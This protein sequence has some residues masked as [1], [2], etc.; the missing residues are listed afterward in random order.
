MKD[1]TRFAQAPSLPVR[2]VQ[3][4]G[5]VAVLSALALA[6]CGGGGAE[7]QQNPITSA[8]PASDYTG[9]APGTADV[10]AFMLNLWTNVKPGNRCGAC[11]NEGGQ[12]PSFG[13]NDDVNLAYQEA[14][15]IVD[16]T[17]PGNSRMVTKVAGGH[18]CW[19]T[20]DS[21]CG[22]IM[23]TWIEGWAGEAAGGGRVITLD[24]PVIKDPGNS[25]NFPA[26]SALFAST[27]Y[28]IVTLY[29]DTCHSSGV[30]IPQ[31]P[32]FAEG[33]VD[34][35]YDAVKSKINLDDPGNSRL[36][37]RLEQDFHNCWDDCPA[38]ATEM[39]NA[40]IA[41]A[42]QIQPTQVD[43]TLVLSKALTLFDGTIASGGNRFENNQ[44]ALWEFKTGS[45]ST[46]FDTSGVDPAINLTLSGD[47]EWVGGWGIDIGPD[48]KAQG[49]TTSS[50]KLN[51]MITPTGEYSIEAW[52]APANVVQEESRI[53]S[54]SAGTMARNFHL[55]QTLYQY[56]FFNRSGVTD[57]NGEPALTTNDADEDLQA[58]LQH[59][60][61]TYDP[62]EGRRIYVNGVFTDDVDPEGGDSLADWDDTF[63]FVLGNEVSGDR[64]WLGTLRLVAIHNRALTEEQIVQNLDV[65]VGEKFF[66]LFSVSHLVNVP[67]AYIMFEVSQFDSFAYLFSGATFISLDAS[68]QPDGIPIEGMRIGINGAEAD[69]G[70]AYATLDTAVT[71]ADYT[72]F[73]QKLSDMGTVIALEKG[74]ESDEF[75][76]TFEILGENA[77]VRTPSIPLAPPPP[78]DGT[79]VAEIGVRTFDEINATMSV[80]TGVSSQ[81]GDVVTTYNTIR[82]QLPAVETIEGFL[83]SHQVAIAQLAIE[84]CN[85]LVDDTAARAAYFPGVNFAAAANVAF[86]TTPERDSVLDPLMDGIVGSGLAS[87]PDAV[88]VKGELNGLIDVLTACGAGCA[89]DRT[90]I[91]VK[92]VCS[93]ALGSAVMLVQ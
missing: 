33:D 42:D 72:A 25:K 59:V 36:V 62:I 82:Q 65:G 67:E 61:V 28:P 16:L 69:V 2:R 24:P 17:S 73:G 39:E 32:Y 44:I 3:R 40:I 57:A 93:G 87:Q 75:F 8:P 71:S 15:G 66:L 52:A 1:A 21:A 92:A 85:A 76:L 89:A 46:A 22:D 27:V 51:D 43:P 20:S 70:Q 38:N 13:R 91:T 50:K 48:G 9:P 58:T 7:T 64:Q 12:A 6:A 54:Y 84:Y 47:V 31:T 19:L 77:N 88:T 11:H 74:P 18:N 83:S 41:F 26:S 23:T 35:A 34:A 10:Q 4:A 56:D 63:A 49:S 30:G 79:P 60:V 78:P 37:L 81:T 53:V 45:G 90:E 29:C 86:D 5:L 68:A 14:V 55:G 80:A